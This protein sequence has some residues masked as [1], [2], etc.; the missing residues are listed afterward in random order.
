MPLMMHGL[1]PE[2]L[3]AIE[4]AVDCITLLIYYGKS[5]VKITPEMWQLFP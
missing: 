1:T 2:G 5:G 3:D 4:D